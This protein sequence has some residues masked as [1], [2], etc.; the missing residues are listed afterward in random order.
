MKVRDPGSKNNRV[1][2]LL[3]RACSSTA[4]IGISTQTGWF[5]C[6]KVERAERVT[7]I[8]VYLEPVCLLYYLLQIAFV[9]VETCDMIEGFR[10]KATTKRWLEVPFGSQ[11]P[12]R[13]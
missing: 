2:N 13:S 5:M 11:I 12:S 3:G 6:R 7:L 1:T 4:I 8:V 10:P 9:L